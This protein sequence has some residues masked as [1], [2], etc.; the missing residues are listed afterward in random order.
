MYSNDKIFLTTEEI[1][2]KE[3][4]IDARGYRLQEVDKFLDT[5]MRDY[6]EFNAIIKRLEKEV[7]SL[8]EDNSRLIQELTRL[9]VN[10]DVVSKEE[11]SHKSITNIDLLRRLSELEKVVFGKE[12]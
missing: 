2:N 6:N 10:V 4:K 11:H 12:E 9:K 7:N 3:F 8:T 5:I 1:L